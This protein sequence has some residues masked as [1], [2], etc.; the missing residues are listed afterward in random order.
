MR[1]SPL[2]FIDIP[3]EKRLDYLVEQ[4]GQKDKES[5]IECTQRI[6]KRLGGLNAKNTIT[7]FNEGNIREAFRI[8]LR[9]Y[10]KTYLKGLHNRENL[11]TLLHE[12]QCTA[13]S[14]KNIELLPSQYHTA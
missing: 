1:T 10:D 5:L 2:F 14:S 13:V 12:I 9:Y 11:A 7:F 8:L 3:F 6:H 4:Y